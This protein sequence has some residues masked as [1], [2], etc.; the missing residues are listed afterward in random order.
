MPGEV[1][2]S[3]NQ[4][5]HGDYMVESTEKFFQSD[6]ALIGRTLVTGNKVVPIRLMNISDT[7]RVVYK[8][9]HIAQ[10]TPAVEVN[11]DQAGNNQEPGL[12]TNLQ[13]LFEQTKGN[14]SHEQSKHV[15]SLLTKYKTLFAESNLDLGK[16][17]IVRHKIE[18]G[19]ARPVKQPPRRMHVHQHSEMDKQI[20]DMLDQDVIEPSVSPWASCVVLVKKKDGSTR[21]CVDYKRLNDVTMK[22][23]YPLPRIDDSLDQLSGSAWFSTLDLCQG[24]WQVELDPEDAPKTAF[25]TRRGLF[26]FKVMPFGLCSAPATFQRLMEAVLAGLQ[27]EICLIYLDDIIIAGRTFEDMMVNLE[28]VFDR[29]AQAG[30]KL[31]AKKCHLFAKQVNFLGHVISE[32]GVA[33]DPEKTAVI[34]NWPTPANVTE[35][36]SFLGLCSYY[37]RYVESFAAKAKCLHL[38]TEKGRPYVWTQECQDAFML[39]KDLMTR[40]PVL[41]HPD[42]SKPLILDTDASQNAIGAVLSQMQDGKERVLAYASRALTKAERRYCVTR[43][44]LLAVVN[45]VKYFRHYLY[46]KPFLVRT[47]HGSLRWLMNFK[48]PEGQLAR[49]LEV[50]SCYNMT[51]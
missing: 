32:E 39:L 40:A 13:T 12:G 24:Y 41:G 50:L 14:V 2:L 4:V 11:T 17:D 19:N 36:R 30:L 43:K 28:K 22:D 18:T 47:D 9:T 6:R 21:F 23:A 16:T 10:M 5:C 37:R 44:E 7:T 26:Q 38:L 42:F 49:W 35:L 46:G 45:F 15:H 25:T 8:G 51:I 29:L 27:W 31:K 3:K 33:T 1:K 20:D 48:E 34:K